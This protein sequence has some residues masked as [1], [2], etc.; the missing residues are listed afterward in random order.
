MNIFNYLMN[1]NNKNL[2]DNDHML[3]YLLNKSGTE[4]E[5]SGT[6]INITDVTKEKIVKLT[7][8][9]ESTQTGTPTPENPVE[10]KTVKDNVKITITDGTNIRNY[11]IPLGN[12]EIVGI[13]NY[14]D[15]LII[16]KKGHCWLNKKTSK[17]V[18]S[19][20]EGF[21][22]QY[23]TSN[24]SGFYTSSDLFTDIKPYTNPNEV[25]PVLTTKFVATTL[26]ATWIPGNVAQV[27]Y[28]GSD[29]RLYFFLEANKEVVDLR[30][31][32]TNQPVYYALETP[33]LIDLNYTV[34]IRLF[35]GVNNITNS[36][37]M[38]MTLIY[39]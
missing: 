15:E 12:N 23:N 30:N 7:L 9:K 26:N 3:E 28:A 21:G 29:K 32:L 27:N 38:N 35:K 31:T 8:D 14:K 18:F 6:E 10:V 34:D 37:D 16:D 33:Q 39:K 11:T 17:Y 24:R 19:G 36:D 20:T 4:K 5:V 13:G 1:K 22:R 25:C 2:V